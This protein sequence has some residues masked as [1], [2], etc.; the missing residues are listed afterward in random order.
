MCRDAY[1][2]INLVVFGFNVGLF[3]Y[4]IFKGRYLPQVSAISRKGSVL[5]WHLGLS[6][7]AAWSARQWRWDRWQLM[8]YLWCSI[9][10]GRGLCD[11]NYMQ[12]RKGEGALRHE[13]FQSR[14]RWKQGA[15]NKANNM[16][17]PSRNTRLHWLQWSPLFR[18]TTSHFFRV[19]RRD[20]NSCFCGLY[21]TS[22]EK[23][24]ATGLGRPV[25]LGRTTRRSTLH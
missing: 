17:I 4:F 23:S 21:P 24:L 15:K 20:T 3:I 7:P 9:E 5:R 13:C 19:I 25:D 1:F 16:P 18:R 8:N 2:V 11:R 22:W 12:H 10:R 6:L 14:I